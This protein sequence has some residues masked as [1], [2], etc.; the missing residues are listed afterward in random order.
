M[1]YK[2]KLYRPT[3]GWIWKALRKLRPLT[4]FLVACEA[5][6]KN[7]ASFQLDNWIGEGYICLIPKKDKPTKMSQF[8]PISLCNV[9]YKIIYKVL[10]QRL[11][12][13]FLDHISK[14]QSAFVIGRQITDNIMIAHEMFYAL[15]RKP[16]D[17]NKRMTIKTYMS[18]AY[19]MKEWAFI[20]SVAENGLLTHFDWIIL[21]TTSAKYKVLMNDQPRGNI[22]H[23]R[24][25]C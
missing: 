11:R 22:V 13:F 9:R 21:C 3:G 6:N 12:K 23:E 4:R 15:R 25:L 14:I 10:C 18:K 7:T 5:G 17:M 19:N 2:I 24:G 8:R 20:R 16:G 1:I